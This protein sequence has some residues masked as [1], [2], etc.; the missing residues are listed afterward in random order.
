MLLSPR[1]SAVTLTMVVVGVTISNN[2]PTSGVLVGKVT[3]WGMKGHESK[4]GM[5]HNELKR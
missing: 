3:F 2:C 5:F 1:V 4:H